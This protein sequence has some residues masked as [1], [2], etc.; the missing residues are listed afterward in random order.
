MAASTSPGMIN[1]FSGAPLAR[2]S[3]GLHT[4]SRSVSLG[5]DRHLALCK[6]PLEGGTT[7]I[8]VLRLQVVG[9]PR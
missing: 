8:S 4:N 1:L 5:W 7:P 3:T 6:H 9:G 2:F